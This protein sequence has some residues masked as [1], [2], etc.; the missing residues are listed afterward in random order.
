MSQKFKEAYARGKEAGNSYI[1]YRIHRA[2]VALAIVFP[3]LSLWQLYGQVRFHNGFSG[4]HAV[5]WFTVVT[6]LFAAFLAY[7]LSGYAK[8]ATT[9]AKQWLSLFAFIGIFTLGFIGF[10][11]IGA[12]N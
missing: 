10:V 12:L 11:F 3:C 7:Y 5:Y 6:A 8:K 4:V 9:T 1:L 2:S